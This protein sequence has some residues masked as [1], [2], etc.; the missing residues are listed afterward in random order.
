[1]RRSTFFFVFVI[2]LTSSSLSHLDAGEDKEV[3]DYLVD[4]SYSPKEITKDN[5]ALLT[6]TILDNEK[7]DVIEFDKVWVRIEEKEN[8]VFTATLS[9]DLD[10]AVLTYIFPEA[11]EYLITARFFKDEQK[12]VETSFTLS[13]E[14]D[15]VGYVLL[16]LFVL[17]LSVIILQ[18]K[19]I[20]EKRMKRKF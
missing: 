11:G 12:M 15:W 3:G 20:Q 19:K 10:Q 17:T 18:Q 9:S 13:V 7:R 1:M 4:F 2:I 6:F 14:D 5:K 16:I 8:I